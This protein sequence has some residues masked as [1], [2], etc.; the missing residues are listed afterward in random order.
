[1]GAPS[2][3]LQIGR[4]L[5]FEHIAAG[6]MA[7]V[8][9]GRLMGEVG[10]T[11]MV[12]IKRLHPHYARNPEFV[13]M[14]TD[15]ARL[16]ARI[17][18]PN[19]VPTLD[20]LAEDGELFLVMDYVHGESLSRLWREA[21]RGGA[22]VPPRIA[23]A[24]ISGALYG[25]HAA[26]EARSE[27]GEPLGL[28]HRDVS[29][30]N[31]LVDVDGVARVLDFGIAKAA[32]RMQTTQEG[33][34]KGKLSYMSPEQLGGPRL[35]RRSD[36][37]SLSV[38]LWE[39]LTGV[40]Y[41][42]SHDFGVVMQK[43]L[44]EPATPPSATTPWLPTALDEVVLRGLSRDPDERFATG[45][46]M[47]LALEEVMPPA[48]AREVGEWVQA[49]ARE[50]L[51]ARAALIAKI[52]AQDGGGLVG[53]R[54]EDVM[55][56]RG[57]STSRP[58]T[59]ALLPTPSSEEPTMLTSPGSPRSPQAPIAPPEPALTGGLREVQ[60][61]VLTVPMG[62]LEQP[63]APDPVARGPLVGGIA[64]QA[65]AATSTPSVT[66]ARRG[67]GL[68]VGAAVVGVLL[69][70]VG[71]LAILRE[72]SSEQETPAL[73][74]PDVAGTATNAETSGSVVA[75][76]SASG[77][78]A[79]PGARGGPDADAT[80]SRDASHGHAGASPD[81]EAMPAISATAAPSRPVVRGAPP[82]TARPRAT[83]VSC[84]PPFFIAKDGTKQYK[85]ECL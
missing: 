82:A 62:P 63:V 18:H 14:L 3:V 11:R 68:L 36:L 33:Q 32:W 21:L 54:A 61:S 31:I 7:S 73:R 69:L 76:A 13:A 70:V 29:P 37:Y 60:T 57:G 9:L 5:V 27:A 65:G 30:Q 74:G 78:E 6:G 64:W 35:D 10:F 1:M 12:A 38:V 52:E 81:I 53:G 56:G 44:Q 45:K 39:M 83:K 59:A 40:R 15:E 46:E 23:V 25:L 24:I 80:G 42:D 84:D 16:A 43:V 58:E 72:V 75:P 19:V 17:R 49:V 22:L 20:V 77:T 47:A 67:A 50:S 48:T 28:V 41:V 4:Y 79:A 26:H 8:H 66:P 2:E 55:L 51:A 71:A 34:L 85:L